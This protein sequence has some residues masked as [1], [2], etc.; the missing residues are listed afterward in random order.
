MRY[1]I[2]AELILIVF[3][4]IQSY[5]SG[6][7]KMVENLEVIFWSISPSLKLTNVV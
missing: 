7:V 1:S 5:D 4:F 6:D 2:S 3:C